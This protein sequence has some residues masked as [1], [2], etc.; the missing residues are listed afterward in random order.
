MRE[1]KNDG[2]GN[3]VPKTKG[4]GMTSDIV[5]NP[6]DPE[7]TYKSKAGKSH[8]GYC[9]NLVEAIDKKGSVIVD[10]Q[11]DVNTRSDASFIKEYLESSEISEDPSAI[12]TDG[13]YTGEETSGMAADKNITLLSMGL[14]DCNPKE[15]LG[16]FELDE[17]GYMIAGCPVGNS[18]QSGSYIKQ[19]DSIKVSF[20]KYQCGGCPYQSKCDP[21]IKE[22]TAP[23]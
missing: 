10:Y 7:A 11:Y 9:T 22:R 12:I 21:N 2:K 19:T 3:R 17:T 20:H 1:I 5:Q 15:I 13:A 14:L 4:D 8:N 16:P 6:S 18:P 23:V